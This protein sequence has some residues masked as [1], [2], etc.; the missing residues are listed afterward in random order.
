MSQNYTYWRL[1][2]GFSKPESD[3][4]Y[5]K[6][7]SSQQVSGLKCWLKSIEPHQVSNIQLSNNTMISLQKNL[8]KHSSELSK[9]LLGR[10]NLMF[11]TLESSTELAFTGRYLEA[12]IFFIIFGF[13][14]QIPTKGFGAL[15]TQT[16]GLECCPGIWIN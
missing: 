1:S 10:M 14:L 5:Q 15:E 9:D 16:R 6:D 8:H 11:P 4:L 13:G 2:Q 7:Q 3:V 12:F